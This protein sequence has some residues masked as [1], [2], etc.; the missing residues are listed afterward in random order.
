MEVA[1]GWDRPV[2]VGRAAPIAVVVG[3]IAVATSRASLDDERGGCG[4]PSHQLLSTG[5]LA[6]HG[7][8]DAARGRPRRAGRTRCLALPGGVHIP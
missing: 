5:Q 2:S 7:C 3:G 6:G 4:Y 1:S 8:S